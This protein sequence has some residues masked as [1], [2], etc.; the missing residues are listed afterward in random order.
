MKLLFV[1]IMI[2]LIYLQLSGCVGQTTPE[3]SHEKNLLEVKNAVIG[4]PFEN[5]E[6]MYI[7]IPKKLKPVD[8]SPGW[9]QEGQKLFI[10][11]KILKPDG[12]T[13]AP[14]VILYYYHTNTQGYYASNDTLDKRILRH[15]AIR[16]W[17]KS[18]T[19][20][21]YG[22]YT[23]RPGAYPNS[24]EPAHIHP[25]IKEPNLD[26]EYY[27][28]EFVFDDDPLLT[29]EKRLNMTNR[30]GSGI[31][32]LLQKEDIHI[33]EHDIILGLNI[34]NYPNKVK[35]AVN[36]GRDIGEDVI[37]FTPFHAWGPDKG[38][39][40]CPICKYGR[41]HGILFF[42]GNNPNWFEIKEWLAFLETESASRS[43]YLKTYFIYGNDN[44]YSE[45]ARKKELEIIGRDLKLEHIALTFVPSFSD[46]NS[47]ISVN[48]INSSVENT[49]LIYKQSRIIDKYENL[50]PT[51]VN[52]DRIRYTLDATTNDL[53]QLMPAKN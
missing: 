11:G 43:T 18:D 7:G 49:I 6:F 45:A 25:S 31:L 50:K 9:N 46:K 28:D 35:A 48:E 3:K 40:I 4:G 38:S 2:T 37:S 12:K 30:G 8:T 36:S 53:F 14:N 34:P 52:F 16:G 10:T 13:P 51:N 27:I 15:G 41:Y 32:R 29:T 26:I 20:G 39:K 17:V 47:G 23:I 33:A 44:Q 5:G 21:N 42:V 24:N 1:Q 22:I 19:N